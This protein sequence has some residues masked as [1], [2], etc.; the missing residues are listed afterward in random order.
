[1]NHMDFD[2]YSIKE[3]YQQMP[4]EIRAMRCEERLRENSGG[5]AMRFATLAQ[6]AMRPLL[7]GVGLAR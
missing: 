2:P 5:R 7:R 4:K 1:M 3:R 6:T